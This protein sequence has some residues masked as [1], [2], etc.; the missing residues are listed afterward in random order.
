M[1]TLQDYKNELMEEEQTELIDL[2]DI[3]SWD[4]VDRFDD[5][6]DDLFDE[7]Y[8]EDNEKEET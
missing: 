2:L 4:L 3:S 1:K 6:V 5:R 7:L 8:D